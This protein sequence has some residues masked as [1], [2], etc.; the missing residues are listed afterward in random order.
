MAPKMPHYT[1]SMTEILIFVLFILKVSKFVFQ[2]T[3]HILITDARSCMILIS[4]SAGSIPPSPMFPF[5]P[6]QITV[7]SGGMLVQ[8][9]R[10]GNLQSDRGRYDGT[11]VYAQHKV[12]GVSCHIGQSVN[13]KI[14]IVI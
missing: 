13:S 4:T 10:T 6:I 3:A 14:R 11:M 12:R 8:K 5:V 1:S 9:L 2:L 7:S